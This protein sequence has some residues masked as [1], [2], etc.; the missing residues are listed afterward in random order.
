MDGAKWVAYGRWI[1]WVVMS[2]VNDVHS[3]LR[4]NCILDLMRFA[5]AAACIDNDALPQA[6]LGCLDWFGWPVGSGIE[7]G[8]WGRERLSRKPQRR[9]RILRFLGAV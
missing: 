7:L 4:S 6:T 5:F 9:R 3:L 8:V 2:I 1:G